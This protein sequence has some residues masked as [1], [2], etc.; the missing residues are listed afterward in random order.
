LPA[1]HGVR[2][3]DSTIVE[4]DV[5]SRRVTHNKCAFVS[6]APTYWSLRT[7]GNLELR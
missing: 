4:H 3:R 1:T 7:L 2:S 6:A 5:E